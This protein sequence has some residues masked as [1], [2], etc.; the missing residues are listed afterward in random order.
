M[1]Y[2]KFLAFGIIG[3]IGSVLLKKIKEEY[4]LFLTLA[5]SLFLTLTAVSVIAPVA[6]YIKELGNQKDIG[7]YISVI[8]KSSG[9]CII[10]SIASDICRD[11]GEN[12]LGSKIDLCGKCT[13]LFMSFPLLR[14]VFESTLQIVG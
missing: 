7:E 6:E 5:V 11:S 10:T 4:S 1:T 14:T 8:F 3:L 2:Y 9:I 13:V 12:A